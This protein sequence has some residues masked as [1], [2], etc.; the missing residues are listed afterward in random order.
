[1]PGREGVFKVDPDRIGG[2]P[3]QDVPLIVGIISLD[4]PPPLIHKISVPVED[5]IP[6]TSHQALV[7]DLDHEEPVAINGKV[8][9]DTCGVQGSLGEIAVDRGYPNAQPHLVAQLRSG[10]PPSALTAKTLGHH[11]G[12]GDPGGFVP[13]GFD[14]GDV[15]T[16]HVHLGLIGT[17][18][19]Y[20]G[21]QG[22]DQTH[23]DT[24]MF[25]CGS[26]AAGNCSLLQ[27]ACADARPLFRFIQFYR[28]PGRKKVSRYSL[29]SSTS[30]MGIST[31][32]TCRKIP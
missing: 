24:S 2:R 25:G 28:L 6:G 29:T 15:V 27:A 21:I 18:S 17:Q 4:E 26:Q 30:P 14:V 19:A 9:R 8:G 11:L 3:F 22:S 7:S 20:T 32:F 16:D 13:H 23:D 10:V 31:P 5:K 12:K 1:M